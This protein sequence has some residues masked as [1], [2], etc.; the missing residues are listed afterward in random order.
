MSFAMCVR[1][2]VY[3]EKRMCVLASAEHNGGV[4]NDRKQEEGNKKSARPCL[5]KQLTGWQVCWDQQKQ[6]YGDRVRETKG[7]MGKGRDT[8]KEEGE[9]ETEE[10]KKEKMHFRSLN[11][12][13]N[14]LK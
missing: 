11:I 3:E 10:Q 5:Q 4:K 12:Y 14:P 13:A 2:F 9:V 6:T 1:A 7:G 8:E